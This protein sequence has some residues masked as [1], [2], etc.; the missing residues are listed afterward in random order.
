MSDIVPDAELDC[1]GLYCPLPL[2]MAKENIANIDIG[3]VLKIQA[4]DP[5]AEKDIPGW[6]K[7]AGHQILMFERSGQVA[8]FWIQRIK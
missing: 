8:T 3:Q 7:R 6:A 1:I 2:S 5:D 4:D